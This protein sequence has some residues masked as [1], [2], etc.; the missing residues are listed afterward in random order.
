MIDAMELNDFVQKF[1]EQFEDT[2]PS[3]ITPATL[4][5]DL[6]EWSSL[7]GMSIIAM[8]KELYG[9]KITGKQIK[10]CG[11]VE[12]LFNVIASS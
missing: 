8:T 10:E 11:T 7:I 1:A 12:D 6:D 9:K 5:H 3:E 2:D 4:Y